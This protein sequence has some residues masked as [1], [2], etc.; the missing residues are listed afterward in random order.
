MAT[1]NR[2]RNCLNQ[3]KLG[4]AAPRIRSARTPFDSL[5]VAQDPRALFLGER[6]AKVAEEPRPHP[7]RFADVTILTVAGDHA[8]HAG[9]V[10]RVVADV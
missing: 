6:R 3:P 5:G 10:E 1:L 7:L 9:A 8:I 2:G 4:A